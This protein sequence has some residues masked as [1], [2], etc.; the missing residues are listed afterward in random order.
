[1]I[2]FT[3]PGPPIAWSRAGKTKTGRSYTPERLRTAERNV[4]WLA[5]AAARKAG[6]RVVDTDVDLTCRFFYARWPGDVSNLVKMVEDG[7]KGVVYDDDRRIAGLDA[8]RIRDKDNPR[9]EVTVR[10]AAAEVSA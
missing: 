3:I 5:L 8:R 9:T 2:S 6:W 10:L 7:M 1:M 4:R